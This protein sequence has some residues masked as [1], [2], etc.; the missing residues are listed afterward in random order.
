MPEIQV[1]TIY[2]LQRCL[3]IVQPKFDFVRGFKIKQGEN[4][5]IL[6]YVLCTHLIPVVNSAKQL[7][8]ISLVQYILHMYVAVSKQYNFL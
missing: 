7:H 3:T 8:F 2:N 6:L 1:S 5:L 4:E